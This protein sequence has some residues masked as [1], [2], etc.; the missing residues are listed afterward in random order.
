MLLYRVNVCDCEAAALL[1]RFFPMTRQQGL[2]WVMLGGFFVSFFFFFNAL[3][4]LYAAI[5]IS[6]WHLDLYQLRRAALLYAL[7]LSASLTF[8]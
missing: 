7:R 8:F 4:V 2:M 6:K 5:P 1:Q 3:S